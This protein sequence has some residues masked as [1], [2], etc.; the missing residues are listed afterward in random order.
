MKW[1]NMDNETQFPRMGR[2]PSNRPKV[3]IGLYLPI[4]LVEALRERRFG[5]MNKVVEEAVIEYFDAREV[6]K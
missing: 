4:Y 1:L 2:P 6:K 3:A 5:P